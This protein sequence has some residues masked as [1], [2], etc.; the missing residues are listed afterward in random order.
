M[1]PIQKLGLLSQSAMFDR[2][3]ELLTAVGLGDKIS[4]P[5]RHLSGGEQQRVAIALANDPQVILADEPTGNLDTCNSE[6]VFGL[7]RSIVQERHKALLL[8]TYNPLIANACDWVHT[9]RD[10]VIKET[11]KRMAEA[12]GTWNDN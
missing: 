1:I 12:S 4:R 9:M 5:G 2:A 10:A 6:R 11:Q 8:V 7:P 3:S